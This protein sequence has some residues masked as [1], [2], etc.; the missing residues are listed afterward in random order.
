MWYIRLRLRLR[1]RLWLRLLV[2]V[3][4]LTRMVYG[5]STFFKVVEAIFIIRLI[6]IHDY[7]GFQ[8]KER[9]EGL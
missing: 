6:V 5:G 9:W 1:L 2:V 7:G 3:L 8:K 4:L